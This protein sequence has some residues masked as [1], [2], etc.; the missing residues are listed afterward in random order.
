MHPGP[1]GSC[2]PGSAKHWTVPC[3]RVFSRTPAQSNNPRPKRAALPSRQCE[4]KLRKDS[5][6]SLE[7][8]TLKKIKKLIN[9]RILFGQ[10]AVISGRLLGVETATVQ[11]R[12]ERGL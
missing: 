1:W 12:K 4:V 2:L 5:A 6:I 11:Q 3:C 8:S 9:Y 10:S 7:L